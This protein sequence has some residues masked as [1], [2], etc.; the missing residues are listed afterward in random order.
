MPNRVIAVTGGKGGVGKSTTTVNLGV[1]LR[2]DGYTVCLVDADVEMPNLVELLGLEAEQTIHDVLSGTADPT[3][4]LVEIAPQFAAI[5]GDSSL[6]GYGSIEPER[7]QHAV[8]VLSDTHQYVILDTGA[9]LS[10]DDLIPMGLADEIILVTSPDPAAVENA[11]RTQSFVRR[12]NREIRGLVVTKADDSVDGSIADEFETSLLAMIPEDDIVRRSTAAG[13]PLELV[14]PDSP[15]AAAY[16]QLEAN[17]TDGVLPPKRSVSSSSS[18]TPAEPE[19][20]DDPTD[21]EPAEEPAPDPT[22]NEIDEG[23]RGGLI[24]RLVK[25]VS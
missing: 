19:D 1:S 6:A 3:D 10:Y 5:P 8:D 18:E 13:Q 21:D 16:R 23:P 11:K 2:M 20:E 12:L 25:L 15:P 7:L 24:S 17:L 9:G 4:A 22:P 14:A